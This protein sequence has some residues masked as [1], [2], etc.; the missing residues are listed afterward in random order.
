M[1]ERYMYERR[2]TEDYGQMYVYIEKTGQL[3]WKEHT[4]ANKRRNIMMTTI[5]VQYII[6]D[7][8]N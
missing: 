8:L 2:K 5:T 3:A 1:H 6:P 7:L 4:S